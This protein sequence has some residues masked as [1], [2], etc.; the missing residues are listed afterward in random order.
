MSERL[1]TQYSSWL[2]P[3]NAV[4]GAIAVMTLYVMYHNERFLIEPANP[5][6]R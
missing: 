4:F 3:K 2:R 1:S 5:I 6:W